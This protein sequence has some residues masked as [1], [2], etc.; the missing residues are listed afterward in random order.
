MFLYDKEF[1][2]IDNIYIGNISTMYPLIYKFFYELDDIL[3]KY[4]NIGNQERIVFRQ[5]NELLNG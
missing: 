5:S 2:G 3:L 4:P 1:T